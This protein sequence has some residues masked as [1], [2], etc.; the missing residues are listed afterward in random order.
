MFNAAQPCLS[1]LVQVLDV[2]PPHAPPSPGASSPTSADIQ[3]TEPAEGAAP[4]PANSAGAHANGHDGAAHAD[5]PL[6]SHEAGDSGSHTSETGADAGGAEPGVDQQA[7]YPIRPSKKTCP[8]Y[9]RTG[10]CPYKSFC[11]F[12]HPKPFDAEADVE[13][14]GGAATS[15]AAAASG[16]AQAGGPAGSS[17]D[18]STSSLSGSGAEDCI[19]GGGED[20]A[21]RALKPKAAGV[22]RHQASWADDMDELDGLGGPDPDP[23]PMRTAAKVSRP[24]PEP[25]RQAGKAPP[26]GSKEARAP[27]S[28]AAAKPDPKGLSSQDV[29][30]A[31]NAAVTKPGFVLDTRGGSGGMV[32]PGPATVPRLEER[33]KQYPRHPGKE[34]CTHYMRKGKCP[35][36]KYCWFDHP[37]A[38]EDASPRPGGNGAGGSGGGVVEKGGGGGGGG[39]AGARAGGGAWTAM[40]MA[41]HQARASSPS[42]P[43]KRSASSM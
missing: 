8:H 31:V 16:R 34:V 33:E 36:G 11:H 32:D 26:P 12:N 19:W 18:A 27:G 14:P 7:Q 43:V 25:A 39:E 22:D 24:D 4:R 1:L 3:D 42:A 29:R 23:E 20:A 13:A 38:G 15:P 41:R 6:L 40:G 5:A 28:K 21:R 2:L 30:A 37:P 17:L 35:Y 9:L 10:K